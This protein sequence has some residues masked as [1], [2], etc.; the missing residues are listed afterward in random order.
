MKRARTIAGEWRRAHGSEL[1]K[2]DSGAS[3]GAKDGHVDF[4]SAARQRDA[5]ACVSGDE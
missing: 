2:L 1:F 5:S 3:A 4:T